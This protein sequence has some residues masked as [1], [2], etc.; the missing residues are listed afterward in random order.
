M[1]P[2]LQSIARRAG[3]H[4]IHTIALT[5]I[6]ASTTYIALLESSLFEPPT[7]AIIAPGH[8]DLSGFTG[9]SRTLV[10]NEDTEWKWQ[11]VHEKPEAAAKAVSINVQSISLFNAYTPSPPSTTPY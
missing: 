9:G 8:V 2:K 5:A 1:I 4:P 10:T 6:L 3:T 11:T 7:R